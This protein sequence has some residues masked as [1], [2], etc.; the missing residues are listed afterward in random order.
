MTSS[1]IAA[2]ATLRASGPTTSRYV[3]FTGNTPS[4]GTSPYVGFTPTRPWADAGFSIEPPVSVPSPSTAKLA[5]TAVA[6]PPLE[7]PGTL[8]TL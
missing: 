1:V 5:F 8:S 3:A 7:P 2:S 4:S 6:V